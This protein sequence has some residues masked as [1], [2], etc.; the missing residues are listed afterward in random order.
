MIKQKKYI[1]HLILQ[2]RLAIKCKYQYRH[3]SCTNNKWGQTLG[4]DPQSLG[5]VKN[6]LI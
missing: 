5:E 3:L 4:Q 2:G 1:I 6:S